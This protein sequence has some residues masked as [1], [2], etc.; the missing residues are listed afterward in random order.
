MKTSSTAK[1]IQNRVDLPRE[2]LV[3]HSNLEAVTDASEIS[4]QREDQTG[5][6]CEDK[7]AGSEASESESK[8]QT[9]Q[10]HSQYVVF[11]LALEKSQAATLV[12]ERHRTSDRD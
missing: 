2:R 4:S 12:V 11:L 5:R 9:A 10:K 8:V 1:H 7:I 3:I 6:T